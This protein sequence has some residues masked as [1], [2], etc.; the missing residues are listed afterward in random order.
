MDEYVEVAAAIGMVAVAWGYG[1][2]M[3][4]IATAHPVDPRAVEIRKRMKE[5][6]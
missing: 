2:M 6:R 3:W 1:A 4:K 5:K